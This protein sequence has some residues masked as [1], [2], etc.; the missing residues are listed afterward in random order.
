M[1]LGS[2]LGECKTAERSEGVG[3]GVVLSWGGRDA[4]GLKIEGIWEAM[5]AKRQEE[6]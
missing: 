4:L 2:L 3:T 5:M 6:D 1:S